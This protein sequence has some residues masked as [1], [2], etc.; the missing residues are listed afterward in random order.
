MTSH[1]G[2]GHDGRR[3]LSSGGSIWLRAWLSSSWLTG[4]SSVLGPVVSQGSASRVI[5]RSVRPRLAACWHGLVSIRRQD[6]P[7][8]DHDPDIRPRGRAEAQEPRRPSADARRR[9]EAGRRGSRLRQDGVGGGRGRCRGSRLA[10]GR[11]G[12]VAWPGAGPGRAGAGHRGPPPVGRHRAEPAAGPPGG[13]V[14][15]RLLDPDLA[16]APARR[17]PR[18]VGRTGVAGRARAAGPLP[19]HG[20]RRPR[21]GLRAGRP[22]AADPGAHGH[23]RL[24]DAGAP[25]PPR[26]PP[27]ARETIWPRRSGS[28][29]RRPRPGWRAT[30][31]GTCRARSST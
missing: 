4:P 30:S 26:P 28:P 6:D 10:A 2:P 13:A 18:P 1:L 8:R 24:A 31:W 27:G 5:A 19:G 7:Q 20:R 14:T 21:R 16:R 11:R 17:D 22:R 12:L 9:C 3:H 15:A 29:G 25:G 23:G